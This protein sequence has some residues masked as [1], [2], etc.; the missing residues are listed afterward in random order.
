METQWV[1]WPLIKVGLGNMCS[2]SD[3]FVDYLCDSINPILCFPIF[4]I[5]RFCRTS[6]NGCF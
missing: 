4:K 6:A 3:I 5:D 1:R 2:L